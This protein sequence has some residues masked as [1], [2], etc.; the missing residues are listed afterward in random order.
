MNLAQVL[1]DVLLPIFLIFGVGFILGKRKNPDPRPIAHVSIFVLLPSLVF[2]SF[3]REDI[4]GSL[5]L[6]GVYITAFTVFMY[7]L[8]VVTCKLLKFDRALQSAFLLSVLFTNSGNY[9]VPLCTFAFGEEG[10]VNALAY[11]T[12]GSVIMYTLAVYVASRGTCS[13]R[14]SFK[15]IFAIPLIYAVVIASVFSYFHVSVP[16]FLVKPITLLGS[17]AIPVA[18]V[19]LGIQLS[20]TEVQK[21][22]KPLVLSIVF[23]L[24][25]SPFVGILITELMGVHGVLRSV[26]ILESSMPTAVNSALIAIEFDAKPG[27][28]STVVLISTVLSI[29]SLTAL[30]LYLT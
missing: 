19:L 13:M 26:L 30:L 21:A 9:G 28:V 6:T 10:M 17:A 4:L 18:M 11:M 5:A 14:D 3:L 22:Y 7:V 15:N 16:S 23:R 12:F 8:S 27:Y 1:V 29:F 20:R 2:T 24:L 25:L